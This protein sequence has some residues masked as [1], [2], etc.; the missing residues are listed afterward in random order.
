MLWVKPHGDV[1][2]GD[3]AVLVE[4][5]VRCQELHCLIFNIANPV[6]IVDRRAFIPLNKIQNPPLGDSAIGREP[7]V[8]IGDWIVSAKSRE[9]KRKP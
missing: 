6:P 8:V 9:E 3:I 5:L 7:Y 1:G 2:T 4:L